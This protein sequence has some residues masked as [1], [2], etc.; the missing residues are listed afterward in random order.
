MAYIIA[1]A[2]W[3]LIAFSGWRV[4]SRAGFKGAMGFLFLIPVANFIALLKAGGQVFFSLKLSQLT[5]KGRPPI[6]V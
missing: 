2:I 3:M 4:F 5:Q 1:I 6:C